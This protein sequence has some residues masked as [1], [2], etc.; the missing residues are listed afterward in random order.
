MSKGTAASSVVV[1][2]TCRHVRTSRIGT[3]RRVELD[4]VDEGVLAINQPR[5]S[6]SDY[7]QTVEANGLATGEDGRES[8]VE[9]PMGGPI[10]HAIGLEPELWETLEDLAEALLYRL[11]ASDGFGAEMEPELTLRGVKLG[12]RDGITPAPRLEVDVGDRGYI[13]AGA[14][15]AAALLTGRSFNNR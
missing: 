9:D 1:R 4:H 13:E 5:A 11:A 2:L 8:P 10:N 12:D 14:G 15:G 7:V 6:E 3:E